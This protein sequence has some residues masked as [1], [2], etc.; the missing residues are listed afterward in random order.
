M[1]DST[2]ISS[3]YQRF[4]GDAEQYL[5]VGQANQAQ[6]SR[7]RW[8]LLSAIRPELAMLPPSVGER[9]DSPNAGSPWPPS[10]P[11]VVPAAMPIPLAAAVRIEPWLAPSVKAEAE[12]AAGQMPVAA[13]PVDA[14]PVSL[15]PSAPQPPEVTAAPA[16]PEPVQAP[17]ALQVFAPAPVAVPAPVAPQ[18]AEPAP[19][20][21]PFVAAQG[22]PVQAA[23]MVAVPVPAV[24][25][26]PAPAPQHPAAQ[27]PV[28]Q[29]A[30][31]PAPARGSLKNVFARLASGS[32]SSN[33]Q[34]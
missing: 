3:L 19:A 21:A 34:S 14:A 10:S 31:E 17:A 28:S 26:V 22:S 23:P 29:P 7:E 20:T 6:A 13:A 4:G 8:P 27:V 5:E 18:M 33:K 11:V 16:Y 15:A 2:D 32:F 12:L 24:A 30:V 1:S 9:A 25:A